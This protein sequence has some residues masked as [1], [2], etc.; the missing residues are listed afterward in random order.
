M[1]VWDKW[2]SPNDFPPYGLYANT[3]GIPRRGSDVDVP[4]NTLMFVDGSI[5]RRETWWWVT[6]YNMP[7]EMDPFHRNADVV[8]LIAVDTHA[9]SFSAFEDTAAPFNRTPYALP[10]YLYRLDQ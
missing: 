8:N 2:V 5:V 3:T 7:L 1:H 10:E 9:K 6:T 4:S